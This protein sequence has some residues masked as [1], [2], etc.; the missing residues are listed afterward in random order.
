LRAEG[1]LVETPRLLPR[2][3]VESDVPAIL[4]WATDPEVVRN[5]SFFQGE[6]DPERVRHSG[7][8]GLHE[9]DPV[10]LNARAGMILSRDSWG[11]GI[12]SEARCGILQHAFA[13]GGSTGLPRRLHHE[14]EG[15]PH[16]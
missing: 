10:N 6:A 9:L 15:H 7:N 13:A 4:E 12:G 3:L 16:L 1:R 5:F 11:R 8:V 2:P 14:R